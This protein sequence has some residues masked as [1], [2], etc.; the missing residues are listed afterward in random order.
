M[1]LADGDH[2]GLVTKPGMGS[3]IHP[4]SGRHLIEVSINTDKT[5]ADVFV[6]GP[7]GGVGLL[8]LVP[9]AV[10]PGVSAVLQVPG[11]VRSSALQRGD[12]ERRR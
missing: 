6:R 10:M 9:A 5:E 12:S 1:Q 11:L 8:W 7:Q 4:Q 3:G 2:I